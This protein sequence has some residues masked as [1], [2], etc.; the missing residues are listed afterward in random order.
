MIEKIKIS[1]IQEILQDLGYSK[2]LNNK[3]TLENL[4]LGSEEVLE[5]FNDL[6]IDYMKYTSG[7]NIT[8][9]GRKRLKGLACELKNDIQKYNHF[10]KLSD[11]HNAR[12]FINNTTLDD[13]AY[14]MGYEKFKKIN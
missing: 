11:S 8:Q 10:M 9:E 14:I 6:D 12:E 13:L 7:G 5:L 2:K 3:D 1:Y 4:E